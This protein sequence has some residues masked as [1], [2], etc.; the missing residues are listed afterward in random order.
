MV[1]GWSYGPRYVQVSSVEPGD[2][3]EN[4]QGFKLRRGQRLLRRWEIRVEGEV[5]VDELP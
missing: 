2:V 5:M 3:P 4:H 1:G